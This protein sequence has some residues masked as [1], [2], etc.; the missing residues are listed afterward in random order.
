MHT[1][2]IFVTGGVVSFSGQG[3]YGGIAGTAAQ[4]PRA[5]GFHPEV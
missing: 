4:E 2:F 5:E 1:K 3:H